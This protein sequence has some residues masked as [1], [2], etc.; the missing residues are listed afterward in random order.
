MCDTAPNA[1]Q[2][3]DQARRPGELHVVEAGSP[4]APTM[5]LIH[6]TAGSLVW[7]DPIVP[8]LAE[9]HHVVRVDLA[10]H[11][12]SPPAR[13]YDVETQANGVSAVLDRLGV[14][15]AT[16]VG[17][18][19]GGL[20]ATALAEQ[21]PDIVRSL[22]LINTGPAPDAFATQ[23][24]LSRLVTL[25]LVGRLIWT[26]RSRGSIGKG[27]STAFTRP[28]EIPD[29][30]VDA[31]HDMTY[32]AFTQA[33]RASLAYIARRSMPA[34]L[35]ELEA[36]V[37][38]IFGTED[39]RWRSQ[40]AESYRAVPNAR[41][42]RLPGVGHTP[43]LEAPQITTKLLLD[44]GPS[45]HQRRPVGTARVI[46]PVREPR[47]DHAMADWRSAYVGDCEASSVRKEQVALATTSLGRRTGGDNAT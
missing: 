45:T 39:R 13:S 44:H 29:A 12:Q 23:G 4:T 14:D 21:R 9:H 5:L 34:R 42:E 43:M 2:P 33:P 16:V 31:V 10:G 8:A 19:S 35:A 36:R 24:P 28:V 47:L 38:V 30:I 20:V 40:S 1:I 37:L 3:I 11:G 18:S 22:V 25:P 46:P 32:R 17:H 26:L 27:L 7:W 15:T 6:G 41:V